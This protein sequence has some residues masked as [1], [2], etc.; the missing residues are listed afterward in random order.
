[1]IV[2]L[3][4]NQHSKAGLRGPAEVPPDRDM[5]LLQ[6][7]LIWRR[8]Q[9]APPALMPKLWELYWRAHWAARIQQ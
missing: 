8:M 6:A 5:A 3:S 1:M 2:D 7:T 4:Q 9:T